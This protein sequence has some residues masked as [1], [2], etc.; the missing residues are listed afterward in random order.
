[1]GD[2]LET[3]ETRAPEKADKAK[4]PRLVLASTSPRRQALLS[5]AGYAFVVHAPATDETALPGETPRATVE[6]LAREKARD[7][8]HARGCGGELILAA[9]T[10][11]VI[12]GETLGKPSDADEAARMLLSLAGRTHSVLTG[13]CLLSDTH[14][15]VH[16]EESQVRMRSIPPDEALA[17]AH[18]GEP[19]DKAGSYALQGEGARFV[20]AVVGSRSNVIGL[21]LEALGPRLRALGLRPR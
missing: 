20:A 14:E 17:Y 11:V 10:V 6:R 21:P 3:S 7:V 9:D 16:V 18:G 8:A 4:P 19:L 5:E 2:V 15:E 13:L 12:D 1:M